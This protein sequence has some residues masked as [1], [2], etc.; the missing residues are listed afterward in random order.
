MLLWLGWAQ[1]RES[2]RLHEPA[3]HLAQGLVLTMGLAALFNSSLFDNQDGHFYVVLSAALWA[4]GRP[5]PHR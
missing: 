5:R 4:L 1:W 2:R 3:N